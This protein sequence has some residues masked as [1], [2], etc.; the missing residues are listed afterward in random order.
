M[1]MLRDVALLAVGLAVGSGAHSA[2]SQTKWTWPDA[3]DA[4]IAAAASH[5]VLL[6]D[7]HVRVLV[8]SIPPGRKERVHTHQWPSVLEQERVGRQIAEEYVSD[9]SGRLVPRNPVTSPAISGFRALRL[10]PE[11][12]HTVQNLENLCDSCD[13]RGDQTPN[14]LVG[15][16]TPSDVATE[17]QS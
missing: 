4:T 16:N 17:T 9:V 14:S 1:A 6:E 8:V 11:G 15:I 12:P 7:A 10:G 3:L 2:A 5:R 13:S